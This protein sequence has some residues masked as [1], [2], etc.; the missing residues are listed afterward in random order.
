MLLKAADDM[1]EW[2]ITVLTADVVE[3]DLE[4]LANNLKDSTVR[5]PHSN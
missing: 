2:I 5:R 4:E 3:C 1:M